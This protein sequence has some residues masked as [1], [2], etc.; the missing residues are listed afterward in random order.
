MLKPSPGVDTHDQLEL[1]SPVP[2]QVVDAPPAS[3][4]ASVSTELL[5]FVPPKSIAVD[6]S[7]MGPLVI[8]IVNEVSA[9]AGAANPTP[10]PTARPSDRRA[11]TAGRTKRCI[12]RV[13]IGGEE[14]LWGAENSL[15]S[16]YGGNGAPFI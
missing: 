6:T 10:T 4:L 9:S 7:V 8:A 14:G 13:T 16:D 1:P 12:V 11:M 2:A 3:V 15:E 5:V